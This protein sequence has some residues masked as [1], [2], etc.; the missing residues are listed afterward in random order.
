M[1]R[2]QVFCCSITR[3][4]TR[5]CGRSCWESATSTR[6]WA[7]KSSRPALRPGGRQSELLLSS[8]NSPSTPRPLGLL[9]TSPRQRLIKRLCCRQ[10]L[11]LWPAAMSV[12]L[13]DLQ[14]SCCWLLC[15]FITLVEARWRAF[16]DRESGHLSVLTDFIAN[17]FNVI[18][19]PTLVQGAQWR[20]AGPADA[21]PAGGAA[22]GLRR[23][24]HLR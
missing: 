21:A 14:Q 9:G 8:L 19:F 11:G 15:R 5:A 6:S 16:S 17:R 7:Y 23:R 18:G 2:G 1:F 13:W 12:L 3:C 10:R 20:A 4:P 24:P 22:A